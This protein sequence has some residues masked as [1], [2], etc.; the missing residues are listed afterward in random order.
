MKNDLAP[1]P[2]SEIEQHNRAR[3]RMESHADTEIDSHFLEDLVVLRYEDGSEFVFNYA[4][5]CLWQ[6]RISAQYWLFV[7]TKYQGNS[8][9]LLNKLTYWNHF[10][11]TLTAHLPTTPI[12]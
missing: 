1:E 8:I 9:W 11:R 10:K 12:K 2:D 7:F 3:T 6:D 5:A 4:T